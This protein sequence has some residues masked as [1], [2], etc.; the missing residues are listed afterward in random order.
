MLFVQQTAHPRP[1][2]VRREEAGAP[3]PKYSVWPEP[4]RTGLKMWW[5]DGAFDTATGRG[6]SDA[7][8]AFRRRIPEFVR[9]FQHTE[10][11]RE[12]V[13]A[14][15]AS[16]FGLRDSVRIAGDTVLHED[17]L[18]AGRRFPDAVAH[19]CFP[20]DSSAIHKEPVPPYQIPY[21]CLCVKGLSNLLVAGRCFSAT[22]TALA[23]ARIMPTG[24]LMGQAAGIAAA[25]AVH[26]RGGVRAVAP[27]AVRDRLLEGAHGAGPMSR[28]LRQ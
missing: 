17:D 20:L 10:Q 3:P 15:S 13:L 21:G 2:V 22:R 25:L 7:A 24:C 14:Y 12:T 11:G 6:Y 19:G 28:R 18:R 27:A 5:P 16:M 23:S 1:Q 8:R 4:D 26:M 9:H